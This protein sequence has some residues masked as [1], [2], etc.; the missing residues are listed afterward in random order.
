MFYYVF[1]KQLERDITEHVK[2][3]FIDW[4]RRRNGTNR[5]FFRKD[6]EGTV[7]RVLAELEQEAQ[8]FGTSYGIGDGGASASFA[9]QL[10]E[11]H[12][13]SLSR[14]LSRYQAFGF[15][16]NRSF[17]D[18]ADISTAVR[19]TVSFMYCYML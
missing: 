6:L 16:I 19:A 14:S 3:D 7:V 1:L 8:H 13:N 2:A 4:R 11:Q 18:V 9:K 5:T 12:A 15:P 17:R 10:T